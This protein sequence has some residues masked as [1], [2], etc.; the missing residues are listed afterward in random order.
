MLVVKVKF[1]SLHCLN[2]I[3]LQSNFLPPLYSVDLL[4]DIKIRQEGNN[5]IFPV[6]CGYCST[7][8]R[9]ARVPGR[10]LSPA[11]LTNPF[12]EYSN[13]ARWRDP[14]RSSVDQFQLYR[15]VCAPS[16]NGGKESTHEIVAALNYPCSP[17]KNICW[18]VD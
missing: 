1:L 3:V 12:D 17:E 5:G 10:I 8:C 4:V 15:T 2:E 7:T 18:V 6:F 11:Y 14:K 9:T 13:Y 16:F